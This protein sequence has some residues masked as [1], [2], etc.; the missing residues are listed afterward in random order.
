MIHDVAEKLN[1]VLTPAD[2]ALLQTVFAGVCQL[3]GVSQTSP[4]AQDNAKVLINLFGAAT[5]TGTRLWQC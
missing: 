2:L 5:E 4:P 1:K 3:R